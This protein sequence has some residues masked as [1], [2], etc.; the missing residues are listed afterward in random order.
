MGSANAFR[1]NLTSGSK[2]ISPT[3]KKKG[4]SLEG[5]QMRKDH[6]LGNEVPILLVIALCTAFTAGDTKSDS[7]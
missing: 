3:P 4:T 2:F 1:T 5:P 7:K 6:W